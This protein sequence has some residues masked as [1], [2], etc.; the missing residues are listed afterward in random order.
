MIAE[1]KNVIGE[2]LMEA[3][4]EKGWSFYVLAGASGVPLTTILH[5]MDGSTKNPGVYTLMRI[6]K[7]LEIPVSDFLNGIE[8]LV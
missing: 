1:R 5:I 4:T 6:C 7:A 8:E 3:C 2:K